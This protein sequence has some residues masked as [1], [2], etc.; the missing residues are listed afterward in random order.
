MQEIDLFK[1]C[2]FDNEQLTI[3]DYLSKPPF[4]IE[5]NKNNIYKYEDFEKTQKT[6][7]SFEKN[8]IDNIY[9]SY[10][11]IINKKNLSIRDLK[12]IKFMNAEIE[13]LI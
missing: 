3:L 9:N 4:R 5:K 13:Y 2:L 10:N 11:K 7:N 1:Y 8:D 6:L 12:L